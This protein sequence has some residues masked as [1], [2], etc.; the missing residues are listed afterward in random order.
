MGAVAAWRNNKVEMV[1]KVDST[2][3]NIAIDGALCS[4]I[5]TDYYGWQLGEKKYDLRSRLSIKGGSRLTRNDLKIDPSIE[6]LCTGLV[7]SEY[8]TPL[9]VDDNAG[10]WTYLAQY[11]KQS[12]NKDNL[13]MAILYKKSD[14]QKL[15]EDKY[16]RI[17]VLSPKDGKL[18]YY[19]LAAWEL[20]PGGVN[21]ENDFKVYLNNTITKLNN[22]V[23][24]IF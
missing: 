1:S 21:N 22:P 19:F 6:A 5:V 16:S 12:L 8:S 15:T 14:L 4:A 7:K 18:S 9:E 11:G 2:T 23:Q 24:I 3:L 13:G 17:V 20:E 10:D